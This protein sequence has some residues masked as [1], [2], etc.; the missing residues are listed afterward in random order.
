MLSHSKIALMGSAPLSNPLKIKEKISQFPYLIAVD[1]GIN[2]CH[3]L[4]LRPDF[5]VGDFDSADPEILKKYS[6][7]PQKVLPRDK[8]QTDLEVA[9]EMAFHAQIEV[10]SIFGALQGRTDHALSN[11]ILISQYPGKLFL[12]SA[13]EQLFFIARQAS[14]ETTPGQ[15][16]SL[17]PMNGP[18]KGVVTQGLKWEIQGKTLDKHFISISNEAS[19]Y[20][21]SVSIQE[22]D[23]LCCINQGGIP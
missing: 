14:F 1:G 13:E 10:I 5:L 6:Q 4:Q 12:E 20:Q 2:H 9:V 19:G 11:L 16:I 8:D 17:L 22:G 3:Q 15:Q 7:V 21:V 18:V 23:L